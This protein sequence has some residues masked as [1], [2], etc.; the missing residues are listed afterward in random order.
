MLSLYF[1]FKKCLIL[2]TVNCYMFMLKILLV[3]FKSYIALYSY[4]LIGKHSHR[5]MFIEKA[6]LQQVLLAF[7]W[8]GIED[9]LFILFFGILLSF[10]PQHGWMF[11]VVVVSLLVVKF[12]KFIKKKK[13]VVFSMWNALKVQRFSMSNA[14]NL[15][16][17]LKS[18]ITCL[19]ILT[20]WIYM[21]FFFFF[22]LIS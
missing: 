19:V 1:L 22:N 11:S 16:V 21:I 6:G 13:K 7:G 5:A 2:L 12:K 10:L 3:P 14:L 4:L 9:E 15:L 8:L 17:Q 18:W 20:H